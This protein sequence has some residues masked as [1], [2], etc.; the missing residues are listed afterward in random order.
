MKIYAVDINGK[1]QS[2]TSKFHKMELNIAMR[3]D[4]FEDTVTEQLKDEM[5]E[6]MLTMFVRHSEYADIEN[7][8]FE[9]KVREILNDYRYGTR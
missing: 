5:H 6:H 7:W 4:D 9:T 2:P 1:F 8:K 3:C